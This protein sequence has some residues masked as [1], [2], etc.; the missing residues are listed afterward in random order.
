VLSY[1]SQVSL[2]SYQ[3]S[4]VLTKGHSV[5]SS[6]EVKTICEIVVAAEVPS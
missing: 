4:I 2:S 1:S 5:S 6:V 3:I